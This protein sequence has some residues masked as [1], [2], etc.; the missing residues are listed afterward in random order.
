MIMMFF[1]LYRQKCSSKSLGKYENPI[2]RHKFGPKIR[3]SHNVFCET[4]LK[5]AKKSLMY[6]FGGY[7]KIPK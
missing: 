7:D 5:I 6:Y 2:M 1:G 4:W 3:E